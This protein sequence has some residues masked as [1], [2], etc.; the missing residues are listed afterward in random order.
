MRIALGVEYDGS[1]FAGWQS[2][3]HRNTVQ[4]V[5]EN[6]LKAIAGTPIRTSCAGRTDTGVHAMVQVVHFD[7]DVDRPMTAW[8]RGVN[9]HLPPAVAVRW[10]QPMAK[11]FHAR[12]SARARSYRYV[13]LNRSVRP[14]LMH[15]RLGWHHTPLDSDTMIAAADHLLGEHDFSAFRAAECQAKSPIKTMHHVSIVRHHDVITLDFTANAFLHHMV[16]NLVGALVD[17]GSGRHDSSWLAE[18]L[19]MRDR[20]RAAATFDAAG[21]YFVRPDYG[22]EWHLPQEGRIMVPSVHCPL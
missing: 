7:T 21:L 15:G 16:R 8:V 22:P 18:L 17:I 9:A 3:T 19:V 14:A 12:F 6:A 4:D 2:Q 13:L 1:P 5:L 20:S 11:E 10:A